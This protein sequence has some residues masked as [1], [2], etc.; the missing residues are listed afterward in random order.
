M[1]Q[2]PSLEDAVLHR[3][4][5]V[6]PHYRRSLA[7]RLLRYCQADSHRNILLNLDNAHQKQTTL[8]RQH[9]DSLPLAR[10]T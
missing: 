9:S 1:N 5:L 6:L 2:K 7:H 10:C 4:V 8:S 3:E